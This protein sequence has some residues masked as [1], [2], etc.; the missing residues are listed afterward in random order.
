MGVI[1]K[2]CIILR[3]PW[4]WEGPFSDGVSIFGKCDITTGAQCPTVERNVTDG[5]QRWWWGDTA[6]Q[7]GVD[8]VD[9]GADSVKGRQTRPVH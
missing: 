9:A 2:R 7:P 6:P 1:F 5:V 3:A 4:L 8:R